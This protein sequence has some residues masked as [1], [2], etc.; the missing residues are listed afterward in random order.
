MPG[1]RSE[2]DIL[3]SFE[4]LDKAPGSKQARRSD[5]PISQRRRAQAMEESNGWDSSPI[6]K[7]LGGKE[8]EMFTIGAFAAALEKKIVTIRLWETKGYIP[9]AP[10]RLRSKMLQG[11]KVQG[12][13]VYTRDLIEITI[14]EFA[15]RGLLGSARI[16]WSLLDDLTATLVTRWRESV[17]S[18]Q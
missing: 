9:L 11:K 13:R 4:G 10:Y 12:N 17:S 8:T 18:S 2:E 16:E 1:L 6:I 15:K 14:V 7:V 5:S 3:R